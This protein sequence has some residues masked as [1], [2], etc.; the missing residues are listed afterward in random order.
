MVSEERVPADQASVSIKHIEDRI[1]NAVNAKKVRCTE[2]FKDYDRLRTGYIT[3]AQ[4]ERCLDQLFSVQL[5]QPETQVLLSKYG[6]NP[7]QRG[8]VCYRDF[9]AAIDASESSSVATIINYLFCK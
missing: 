8:M 4:F 1:R 6:N 2:Y 5:S 3:S 7:Q 9:C